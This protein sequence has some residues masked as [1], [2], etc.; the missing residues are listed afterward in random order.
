LTKGP[1]FSNT[2]S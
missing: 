2:L 1:N